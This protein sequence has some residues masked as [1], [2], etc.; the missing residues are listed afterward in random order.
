MLLGTMPELGIA[1]AQS[2]ALA[3]MHMFQMTTDVEDSDRW[4]TD[5]IV[6]PKITVG[7]SSN[8]DQP[9]LSP[10]G[11]AVDLAKLEQY[12]IAMQE[13]AR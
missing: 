6:T 8:I 4:F 12:T 9:S 2:L 3:T 10:M 13:F 5:D 11:Y 7:A 1:T